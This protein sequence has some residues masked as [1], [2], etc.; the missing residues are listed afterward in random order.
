[1]RWLLAHASIWLVMFVLLGALSLRY[2]HPGGFEGLRIAQQDE[3]INIA[4]HTL[5][6]QEM[7]GETIQFSCDGALDGKPLHL[8]A[9]LPRHNWLLAT[10]EL[11][12]DGH[13]VT[14][15]VGNL[16]VGGR[17]YVTTPSDL[18]LSSGELQALRSRNWPLNIPADWLT[19]LATLAALSLAA[20]VGL[21]LARKLDGQLL[22]QL[23][24]SL[25]AS[26]AIFI[27]LYWTM[28]S[29]VVI[30]GFMD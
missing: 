8:R 9:T 12:F 19:A 2:V 13:T 23:I 4:R 6:C 17:F 30:T 3:A 10:C 5:G 7:W 25:A 28:R 18:G 27:L 14:C 22:P 1:M 11:A 26:A 16:T 29:A 21:L 20:H 24:A 15:G